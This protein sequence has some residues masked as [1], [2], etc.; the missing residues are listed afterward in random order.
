MRAGRLH[1]FTAF[2]M[3]AS[4]NMDQ[5]MYGDTAQKYL[6]FYHSLLSS[7]IKYSAFMAGYLLLLTP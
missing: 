3:S 5:L 2:M 1:K 4:E 7:M 6:I